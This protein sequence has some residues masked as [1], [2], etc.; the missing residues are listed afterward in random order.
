MLNYEN[1]KLSGEMSF[2]GRITKGL[3]NGV[4]LDVGANEG[5][6]SS[7]IAN[8]IPSAKIYAFEPH[9][10]TFQILDSSA[11]RFDYVAIN[12]ACGDK[13]GKLKLY[14]YQSSEGSQ[15]ASLYQDVIEGLH[16]SASK[17]WDVE[18]TTI[19]EFVEL[20]K[21]KSITL[22]K[23]DTE[24]NELSVLKGASK[25]IQNGIV[26]VIHFE[27]NSMNVVSKV[28]FKDIYDLLS[29]YSFYRMLPNDLVSMGEYSALY[30]EIFAYQ[31][32]VAVNKSVADCYTL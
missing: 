12:S 9:P 7:T 20:N 3:K 18:V 11:K 10:V 5:A 31:N 4:V 28:F 22:L 29:N 25:S 26:D 24:G 15:H 13:R 17:N 14:D 8:L 27:F 19:D 16:K 30:W 23:I 2:L 32:I 6:Y 21:I 1:D